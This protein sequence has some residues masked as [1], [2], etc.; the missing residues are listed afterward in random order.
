M[1]PTATATTTEAKISMPSLL[2]IKPFKFRLNKS[3]ALFGG[4]KDRG[5][6]G[7]TQTLFG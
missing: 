3:V 1:R 6:A 2:S 4:L 5:D 7:L